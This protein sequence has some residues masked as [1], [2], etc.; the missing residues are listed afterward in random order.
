M[1]TYPS[2]AELK[3]EA[4]ESAAGKEKKKPKGFKGLLL[5][6]VS[7]VGSGFVSWLVD[8]FSLLGLNALFTAYVEK[9]G[10]MPLIPDLDPKLPAIVIARVLSSTVN[11]FLNRRVVFRGGSRV[12]MLLYFATVVVLLGANYLLLKLFTGWGIPLWIA[13]LCAQVIIYPASFLLQKKVV[14]REWKK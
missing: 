12:S 2:E 5:T 4:D 7:F 13:Q 11:Y 10:A 6:F 14:F 9:Y 3:K 8:Y 1:N